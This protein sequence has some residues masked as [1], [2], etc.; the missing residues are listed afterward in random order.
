[1]WLPSASFLPL[2]DCTKL[3][4]I[5]LPNSFVNIVNTNSDIGKI[6]QDMFNRC[7][8]LVKV[9]IPTS[10]KILGSY[11]FGYCSSLESIIIPEG[12]NIVDSGAFHSCNLKT[13]T[14]PESSITIRDRILAFNQN[15]KTVFF[16][17]N[18]A[19][20][21][22]VLFGSFWR[23][24]FTPVLVGF[25]AIVIPIALVIWVFKTLFVFLWAC[26]P[27]ILVAGIAIWAF[28]KFRK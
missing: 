17:Q 28:K 25:F 5:T 8:S 7:S 20:L 10:A 6:G 1:M 26:L 4:E 11:M 3:K 27:Y 14:F 24:L 13:I 2:Q 15:L 21:G 19:T 12:V 18:I 22:M 23:V 9:N 16:G